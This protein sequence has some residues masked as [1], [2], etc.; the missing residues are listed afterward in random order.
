MKQY[1]YVALRRNKENKLPSRCHKIVSDGDNAK[2][3]KML[4]AIVAGQEGVWRIYRS[5]NKRDLAKARKVL[6][7]DLIENPENNLAGIGGLWKSIVMRPESKG[8]RL[9]LIDID[10]KDDVF[11]AD[12]GRFLL[13]IDRCP[14]E[15]SDTPNGI[16]LVVKPFDASKF[17]FD[18]VEIKKDA[19]LFLYL[20]T[21]D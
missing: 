1:I 17:N 10:T 7:H 5:V 18:N 3:L 11:I 12:V 4:L 9:W 2:A 8:E 14:I 13:D 15:N 19:L 21:N 16:H 20:V 6:L